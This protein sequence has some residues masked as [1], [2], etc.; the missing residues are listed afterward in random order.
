MLVTGY[1]LLTY[2]AVLRNDLSCVNCEWAI[3]NE[4]SEWMTISDCSSPLTQ[5]TIHH[6]PTVKNNKTYR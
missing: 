3:V 6:C 2:R 5:L 1:L 4:C